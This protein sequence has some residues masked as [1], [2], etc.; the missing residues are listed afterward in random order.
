MTDKKQ[1]KARKLSHEI[2]GLLGIVF[3]ISVFLFQLLNIF[4]Y[5]ICNKVMMAKQIEPTDAQMDHL[6]TLTFNISLIGTVIFFTL[7]FLFLLGDRLTYIRDITKGIQILQSGQLDHQVPVEGNNELT[8]LARSINYLSESQ[9]Q[10][11]EKEQRLKEE[12]EQFIRT[13]SHD[14]RTPLTSILA[15]SEL[16][17]S[18]QDSQVSALMPDAYSELSSHDNKA[19]E[20]MELIHKK[21]LQIK[22]MTDIL[23]DG[24]KRNVTF[25]E[26][27]HL[28]IEQLLA[29]FEGILEDT[30]TLA[31]DLSECS[32]FQG[33]FDIRELQ[34]IFD[35]LI[36]NIQ[37]YA[38][39]AKPVFLKI[40]TNDSDIC[41]QQKNTALPKNPQL[42]SYQ[43]GLN[44]IRRIA[45]NYDGRVDIRQH[46]DVFEITIVLSYIS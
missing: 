38:D 28:L 14:I 25:F 6:S 45:H 39:P 27:G 40:Y 18:G 5:I 3:V 44:S 35:N 37:K 43:M 11:K 42:E 36:S 15:Y 16:V 19:L 13:M 41:I 22:D 24:G 7:L 2:L 4:A 26:N 23:L 9:K 8:Q 46:D 1:R 21:A 32:D 12:K 34:R 20:Y 30:F 10:I 29:D 31:T 33:H 17:M